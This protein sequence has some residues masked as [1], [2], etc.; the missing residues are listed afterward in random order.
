L[1]WSG[2]TSGNFTTVANQNVEYTLFRSGKA[3]RRSMDSNGIDIIEDGVPGLMVQV[4]T[5]GGSPVALQPG[6]TVHVAGDAEHFGGGVGFDVFC[7]LV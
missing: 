4:E 7:E 2:C 5:H 6:Q 3:E 1:R